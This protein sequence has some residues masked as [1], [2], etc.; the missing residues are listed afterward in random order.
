[1]KVDDIRKILVVGTGKM[2]Q[3]IALQWIDSPALLLFGFS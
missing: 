2:G 1:M 3:K